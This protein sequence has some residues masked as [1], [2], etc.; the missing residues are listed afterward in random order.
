M[1]HKSAKLSTLS[2]T[3]NLNAGRPGA[4]NPDLRDHRVYPPEPLNRKTAPSPVL[5][6]PPLTG[7]AILFPQ[8]WLCPGIQTRPEK[9][10]ARGARDYLICLL[11]FPMYH[12]IAHQS[13]SDNASSKSSTA[14][15]FFSS[16]L[17]W[18]R[19]GT[20]VRLSWSGMFQSSTF[21]TMFWPL[22]VKRFPRSK[23]AFCIL[24]AK[25]PRSSQHV[26]IIIPFIL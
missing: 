26:A 15:S 21:S 5:L 1:G 10:V 16:G 4:E 20:S 11:A 3:N 9:L 22:N 17:E 7:Q 2:C 13:H 23:H 18:G 24:C 14:H 19:T 8:I 25:I 12:G 6:E